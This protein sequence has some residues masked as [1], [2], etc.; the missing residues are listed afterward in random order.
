M[1]HFTYTG[2]KTQVASN[3]QGNASLV[4]LDILLAEM[5]HSIFWTSQVLG[6]ITLTLRFNAYF[7]LVTTGWRLR[8]ASASDRWTVENKM[9]CR[10]SLHSLR[11]RFSLTADQ[12]RTQAFVLTLKL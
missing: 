8:N 12:R 7:C 10:H 6:R 11:Q 3:L 9:D 5:N 1:M 4:M 2:M